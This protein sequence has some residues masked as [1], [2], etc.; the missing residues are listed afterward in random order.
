M[1]KVEGEILACDA[2]GARV[3]LRYVGDGEAD[4]GYTKWRKYEKPPEG[5][6]SAKVHGYGDLCPACS[7]RANQA[8][9]AALHKVEDKPKVCEL[10]LEVPDA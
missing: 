4:G 9:D 10:G 8:I 5:W 6:N 3:F 7:Q 1:S 2:C